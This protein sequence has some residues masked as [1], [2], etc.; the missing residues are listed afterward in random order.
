MKHHQLPGLLALCLLAAAHAPAEVRYVDV[1]SAS[2]TPPYGSWSTAAT[3]IQDAVDAAVAGDQIRVTN[4]VYQTGG[5][6]VFG[7]MTNRVAVDKAVTV[8]SVNGPEFTLIQGYQV[9]VTTRGDG[10]IRC[11]YL[12]NGASLSGFTLTNGATRSAG[13]LL[14]ER[15]GGGVWC[16]STSA[17]ISNCVV[18]R[19]SAIYGGGAQSG[20]FTDCT[21]AG[22]RA[23]SL[24]GGAHDGTLI[25]CT[26][27]TN[28]AGTGGGASGGS[29]TECTLTG[30]SAIG[31]GGGASAGRLDNCTLT[32]NS[33]SHQGGGTADCFLITCTLATN[34]A[35]AGGGASGGFLTE[36]TLIGNSASYG[37]GTYD[38]TL[39]NSSLT[40]N[41]VSA[42]NASGGGAYGGVLTNC[43]LTG[44]QADVTGSVGVL[45]GGGGA[46]WATLY[47]CTLN[48][49]S[50]TG[51]N[52][53]GGGVYGGTLDDCTLTG[54][55]NWWGYGGGASQAGLT[56]CNLTYNSAG[57]DGGGAVG[58]ALTHCTLTGNSAY[59]GGGGAAESSLN[60][61]R[62]INNFANDSGGGAKRGTLINCMLMSNAVGRINSDSGFGGGVI[63]ANLINCTLMGNSALFSG[64]VAES[65]LTNCIVYYNTARLFGPGGGGDNYD[66]ISAFYY[67]C[68][69]PPFF[70]GGNV[71]G[72]ITNAPLFVDQVNGNLRLQ[73][74]SPCINAGNWF[75]VAAEAG[76]TD[77]DGRPRFRSIVDMGAYEYQGP[78]MGEFIAWLQQY[79]LPSDGSAD[80][81]DSDGD[82]IN[83][84]QEWIA[85]TVPTDASS[86]LRLLAPASGVSGL[87]VTW[88]SVT[89]RTYFLERATHLGATPPPP[90]VISNLVGQA[91][92]TSYT[93]TN[94]TGPGPFFYRVGVQP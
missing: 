50:V 31:S 4:G 84:W 63:D 86:A 75:T 51:Y 58:S 68:T 48:T 54:N 40:G 21:L 38:S 27:T 26:L 62:L 29:L 47:H 9:P 12:T 56:D 91:G 23:A 6:A 69:T 88:Q 81:T 11:V 74:N 8:Q 72:N 36:C 94:A 24:G 22:N 7:T 64:G 35:T 17:V 19:N 18:S 20:T 28:R 90:V 25:T 71:V 34:R 92:T 30:N 10:A 46:S 80:S 93:D 66:N 60:N 85:G 76:S 79:S 77:L 49:N 61:C 57:S 44:N 37:G 1:N 89:N 39:N 73:S 65:T 55:T 53:M 83:N 59:G 70:G 15:S 33:A 67:S 45:A 52:G 43:R 13:D 16:E 14:L 87:T 3:N 5:K 82:L 2:P 78:G 42:T 41:S 32:G